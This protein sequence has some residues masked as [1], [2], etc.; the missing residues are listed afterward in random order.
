MMYPNIKITLADDHQIFR[1]GIKSLLS[2]EENLSVIAEASNSDELLSSLKISQPDILILDIS[3]PKISGIE[4]TKIISEQFP[5]VN[6]LILSMHKNEDFVISAMRNGAKG[7]LPKD[8][9]RKE[10]LEAIH[11]IAQGEEYLGKL[12]SS[13]ILRSYINKSRIGFERTD[14]EELLTQREKEIIEKVGAGLSNKE[15]ADKLFISVRTVDCH[16]NNIMKKLKIKSTAEL[17]IYGIKN[18][19]IEISE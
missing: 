10:L 14:K 1:D 12:I 11:A 2:D 17:I 19:I 5:L 18:K 6:I 9:S 4:L 8:T 7:Y 15:I 13:G 16:K 3:M